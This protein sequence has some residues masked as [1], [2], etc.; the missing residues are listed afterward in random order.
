[1][2]AALEEGLKELAVFFLI[3][4]GTFCFGFNGARPDLSHD[5]YHQ[6]RDDGQVDGSC[7]DLS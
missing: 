7:D 5:N 1:M 2:S 3:R 4:Y 6:R